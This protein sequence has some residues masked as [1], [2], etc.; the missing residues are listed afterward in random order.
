[1]VDTLV[2]PPRV[3]PRTPPPTRVQRD[4]TGSVRTSAAIAGAVLIA[5]G[6]LHQLLDGTYWW[7]VSG[8]IALIV[9]ATI[10]AVRAVTRRT[11]LP[12][13]VGAAALLVLLTL[14]FASETAIVGI[15]PTFDT[16]GAF[17]QLITRGSIS[18][19]EQGVP[20]E[21]VPGILFLLALG[22]GVVAIAAD[23]F[24]FPAHT[25]AL[26][27]VPLLAIVAV[28]GFIDPA[29]SD[30]LYFLFAA[31]AW[32][33]IVY[34][35]SPRSQPGVAFGIAAGALV[36][37]LVLPLALP[38][39]LPVESAAL[40]DG[41]ATGLNPIIDL[42]DDLRRDAPV[43][44][45]TYTTT[46]ADRQYLRMTTLEEFGDDA[47]APTVVT[48][49]GDNDPEAIPAAPGRS[50]D[51]A[52]VESEATI[53]VGNVRGRW[54]PVPYAP[55]AVEGLV[56]R[57]VWDEETL[58]VRS[59]RATV[60]GQVYTV[61]TE[62]ADPTSDQLRAA[63][64]VVTPELERYLAVPPTLPA[65]VAETALAVTAGATNNYDRAMALQSYFRGGDF[66]YS[67]EAPVDE[68]YD[69]TGAEIIAEFLEAK[70]GYC[71]HFS[72]A[73]AAMARTLGIPARIA[74]GFTTGAEVDNASTG[75]QTFR[76]T[77]DELHAWPELYFAG[78]GW[79]RFEPTVSRNNIPEYSS[80]AVDDPATP[81]ID[82]SVATPAPTDAA[83]DLGDDR[84]D[85]GSVPTGQTQAGVNWNAV[86]LGATGLALLV[87]LLVPAFAR[88]LRRRSRLRTVDGGASVLGAW[89]ELRDTALDLGWTL[90]D[91]ETPREF[92]A[93]LAASRDDPAF[94]ATGPI[95]G[96]PVED[97]AALA[98]LERLREAVERESYA[99]AGGGAATV[100]AEEPVTVA[101]VRGVLDA[102]RD[103]VGR[104]VRVRAALAPTSILASWFAVGAR[105][106]KQP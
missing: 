18:I 106:R 31:A 43:V 105:W 11:L 47:W 94:A 91:A 71:V 100:R 81:D 36:A 15:I 40:G 46:A 9:L 44:A 55:R 17:G 77:T 59:E 88:V 58:N 13:A 50:P 101:E 29:F 10:A 87:L 41:Y 21:A 68:G 79:T 22:A 83:Q 99:R 48:G 30:P 25:P 65:V 85:S 61:T 63:D 33:V 34:V 3:G 12:T 56:G 1:M 16:V 84:L 73:M 8:G 49:S 26:T 57:W 35:T 5:L 45:L 96:S 70:S 102:L 97:P 104:G 98:V 39:V 72:S 64:P 42:G 74:V 20:A 92:A 80:A 69:G 60:R 95:G 23:T 76:V 37:G 78:V 66:V 54:L 2:A 51:V 52:V 38:P 53:T 93:R 86:V 4:S 6:G 75:G 103:G 7:L 90:T 89:D 27:G 28:P 32:L 24:S 67:E 14:F 19:Q 82:E 62:T